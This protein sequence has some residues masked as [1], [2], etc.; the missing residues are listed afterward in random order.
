M[1][2]HPSANGSD[3]SGVKTPQQHS[4]TWDRQAG[5]EMLSV[6]GPIFPVFKRREVQRWH[7]WA[8]WE[9]LG[10]SGLQ[11]PFPKWETDSFA[12]PSMLLVGTWEVKLCVDPKQ[13]KPPFFRGLPQSWPI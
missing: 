3:F 11:C 6:L 7:D 4:H 9:S 2:Q 5:C 1:S 10:V 8:V 13:E 12:G